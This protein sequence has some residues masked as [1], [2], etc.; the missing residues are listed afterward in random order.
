MSPS[1]AM[2]SSAEVT[3][4]VSTDETVTPSVDHLSAALPAELPAPESWVE[5]ED[6]LTSLSDPVIP[7]L[8]VEETNRRLERLGSWTAG[9]STAASGRGY[10]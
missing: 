8:R 10:V 6:G 3:P 7:S 2:A 9:T 4:T 5:S 1:L